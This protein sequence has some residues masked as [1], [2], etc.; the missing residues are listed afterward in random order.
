MS[1]PL[2]SSFESSSACFLC[3]VHSYKR[4][5]PGGIEC[6]ILARTRSQIYTW[7]FL[8]SLLNLLQYCFSFMLVLFVFWLWGVCDL[9]SPSRDY[10][11]TPCIER[12]RLKHWTAKEVPLQC[13]LL[14]ATG[15]W[16]C[17]QL[18]WGRKM[19]GVGGCDGRKQAKIISFKPA[20]F[21]M[22]IGYSTENFSHQL[23]I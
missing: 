20:E 23:C 18:R 1:P 6:F 14:Y 15:R 11:C 5:D 2:L 12:Q 10:T 4:E 19:E 22:F 9:S 17:H 21:E 7:F 16:I 8:K 13:F 3:N